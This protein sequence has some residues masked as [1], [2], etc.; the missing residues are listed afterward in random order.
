[1]EHTAM[2]NHDPDLDRWVA[3]V[4]GEYREMPGLNLTRAQ[5]RRMWGL[6]DGE[7]DLVLQRLQASHF[8]RV[9]SNG[10]YVLAPELLSPCGA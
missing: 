9:T 2:T 4:K 1:L 3:M 10:S 5:V 7:C 6:E 8:L